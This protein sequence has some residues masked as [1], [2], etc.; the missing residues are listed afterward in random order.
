MPK[1]GTGKIMSDLCPYISVRSL[2]DLIQQIG[3]RCMN[4]L[5]LKLRNDHQAEIGLTIACSAKRSAML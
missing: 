4:Y 1:E 3:P 2:G 5:P